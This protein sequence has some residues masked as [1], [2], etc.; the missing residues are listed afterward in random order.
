MIAG[1]QGNFCSGGDVR[2]IIGP[3]TRDGH[4]RAAA[5]HAHDRRSREG[6]PRLPAAGDRGDRRRLR[7]RGR[8][9]RD[10]PPTCGSARRARR[11]RS[12]SRASGSRAAT[13]ARARC[14]RGS[15]A[16]AAPP[17][18]C[19]R[20]ARWA[21]RRPSAGASSTASPT[22]VEEAAAEL[23]ASL[24][25]GP[26]FAHAMT[27]TMLDQEWD[28]SVPRRDRG[29]GAGAGDLHA[30][31]GLRARLPRVPGQGAAGLRGRLTCS[32]G[33]S[34][35]TAT[36]SSRR[37]RASTC[38]TVAETELDARCR[39]VRARAGAD[40]WLEHCGRRRRSTCARS[41]SRARRSPTTTR[42]PTS[43]SRCR[44]SAPG[45]SRCSAT[46]RCARSYLPAVAAGEKIAAFAL[47]EP[48]AGLR[49][50]GDDHDRRPT[51]A[52]T[53]DQDLDLQRRDR[54][55]LHGV[56]ARARR[57]SA[58]TWSTRRTSRSPSGST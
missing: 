55:L 57:A 56:R 31:A 27:K 58:R 4:A 32:S 20:A 38:P 45:R 8:D 1:E 24:A 14:C 15:S 36:A 54:G 48:D 10:A 18:C 19:S 34:S 37:R 33:R 43:R 9:D 53:G 28:M 47:S 21:P 17:S 44:G 51:A 5:L 39:G 35:R 16:R 22:P 50:G 41:A 7:R 3:L 12:C 49:R 30:D 40:G 2:D 46:T 52:L 6:D 11:S 23:A 26:T 42:W 13:W 29:R 25:S